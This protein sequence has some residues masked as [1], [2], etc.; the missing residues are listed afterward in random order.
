[1]DLSGQ[2]FGRLLVIG[3][4]KKKSSSGEYYYQCNC[5]CGNT[6]FVIGGNL[7]SGSVASCGCLAREL[8]SKRSHKLFYK[9]PQKCIV[10]ECEKF[11]NKGAFG[12]CGMHYQRLR[13]YADIDFV[14][15]EEVRVMRQR[16]SILENKQASQC[17]YKKYYGRH[18]HRQ[19]GE[20]KAGRALKSSEHVHHTDE[21]KHNNSPDNL[22]I[23]SNS[24]HA[25]VHH[26]R[27]KKISK[28]SN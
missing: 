22:E 25:R 26:A 6:H 10:K 5:D 28:R 12:Y 2:K 15:P 24:D 16:L 23:L 1:M 7:K 18:E 17:S 21:N 13:R 20:K 19:A 3:K 14:T 11:R 9:G 27:A 8:S 4:V